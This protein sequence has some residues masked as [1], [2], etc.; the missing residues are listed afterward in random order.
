[1]AMADAARGGRPLTGRAVFLWFVCFFAPIFAVNFYM[2]RMAYDTF[3]GEVVANPYRH[4]L[5]YD[6]LLA[7]AKAQKARGW[8]VDA[9]LSALPGGRIAIEVAPRDAAGAP[10]AGLTGAAL[11]DHP[12]DARLNQVAAFHETSPGLYRATFERRSDLADVRIELKNGGAPAY[13]SVNRV[14]LPGGR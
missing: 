1:M 14:A 7:R 13:S 4:G 2:A 6:S 11:V 9:H 12:V 8:K 10:V 5:E 3:T